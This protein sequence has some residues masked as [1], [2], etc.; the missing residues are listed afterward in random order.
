[1]PFFIC[2]LACLL[3]WLFVCF[4]LSPVLEIESLKRPKR[5]LENLSTLSVNDSIK[6]EAKEREIRA[7]SSPES[8]GVQKLFRLV[9]SRGLIVPPSRHAVSTQ[10]NFLKMWSILLLFF[11]GFFFEAV[12]VTKMVMSSGD[13]QQDGGVRN[14]SAQQATAAR[15]DAMQVPNSPPCIGDFNFQKN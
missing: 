9:R 3:A 2:L 5:L 13:V 1:M 4:D 7:D 6:K 10:V 12:P 14:V 8:H 11:F 15:A